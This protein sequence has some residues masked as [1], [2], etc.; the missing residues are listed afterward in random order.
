MFKE[1]I[2]QLKVIIPLVALFLV[3]GWAWATYQTAE[4]EAWECCYYLMLPNGMWVC[5]VVC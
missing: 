5:A 2:T 4:A 3:L 1:L